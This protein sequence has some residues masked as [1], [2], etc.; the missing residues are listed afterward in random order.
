MGASSVLVFLFQMKFDWSVVVLVAVA[1]TVGGQLGV[2]LLRRIDE[3][4]LN[5][6]IT[7]IGVGLTIVLFIRS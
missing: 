6:G 1:A 3:T 2:F 7:L 5:I 4:L